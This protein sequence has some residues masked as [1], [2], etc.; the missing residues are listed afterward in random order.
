MTIA[1]S[2]TVTITADGIQIEGFEAG[3]VSC[4]LFTCRTFALECAAWAVARL[5]AEMA[6][7]AGFYAD[8]K[9]IDTIGVD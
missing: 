3:D 2:G 9:P 8:G 1:K 6:K 5:G 4:E 7:S